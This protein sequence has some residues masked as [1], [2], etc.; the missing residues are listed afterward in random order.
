MAARR[1][2]AGSENNVARRVPT[3]DSINDIEEG[4]PESIPLSRMHMRNMTLPTN[5][6]KTGRR[7][8]GMQTRARSSVKDS[9]PESHGHRCPSLPLTAFGTRGWCSCS[10]IDLFL[11][12]KILDN[13]DAREDLIRQRSEKLKVEKER[14]KKRF[15]PICRRGGGSFLELSMSRSRQA[16]TTRSSASLLGAYVNLDAQDTQ[17]AE[18]VGIENTRRVVN[19]IDVD[20]L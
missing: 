5:R 10:E 9:K 8:R 7:D 11:S 17:Q 4:Q 19:G 1:K 2:G 20:K 6:E 16:K 15:S 12:E 13:M 18:H 14:E 3:L